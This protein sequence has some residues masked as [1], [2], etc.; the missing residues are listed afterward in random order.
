MEEATHEKGEEEREPESRG[1]GQGVI[2]GAGGG[3]EPTREGGRSEPVERRVPGAD[4]EPHA[5]QSGVVRC[6]PHP[7]G[8]GREGRR[9]GREGTRTPGK[10]GTTPRAHG[11]EQHGT[12]EERKGRGVTYDETKQKQRENQ[13]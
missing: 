2:K 8:A 9:A 5:L 10:G 11:T 1:E 12:H 4:M 7:R 13:D 6:P 3:Q